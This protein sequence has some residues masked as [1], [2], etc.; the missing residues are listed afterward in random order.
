MEEEEE[1]ELAVVELSDAT[2]DPK[3]VM[4]ILTYA[5]PAISTVLTPVRQAINFTYFASSVV[6]YLYL[7]DITE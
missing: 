5:P 1:P 7:L 3:A 6:W 2:S 4:I